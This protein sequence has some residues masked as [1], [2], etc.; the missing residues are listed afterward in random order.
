[1]TKVTS[2][3]PSRDHQ[4]AALYGSPPPGIE[5][6]IDALLEK[7]SR[8]WKASLHQETPKPP[9]GPTP[10]LKSPWYSRPTFA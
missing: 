3:L 6:Y 9:H 7:Q 4:M 2:P 5:K 1:M 10:C 8:A